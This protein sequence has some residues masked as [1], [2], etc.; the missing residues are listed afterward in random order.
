MGEGE[1][2][3]NQERVVGWKPREEGVSGGGNV[4]LCQMMTTGL[5]RGVL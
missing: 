5:V 2:K 3:E 4:Q 1:C